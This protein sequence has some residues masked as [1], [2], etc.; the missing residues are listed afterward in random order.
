MIIINWQTIE[1]THCGVMSPANVCEH[2]LKWWIH[3]CMNCVTR[4]EGKHTFNVIHCTNSQNTSSIS[5]MSYIYKQ[6][7]NDDWMNELKQCQFEKSY[8]RKELFPICL[9]SR[10]KDVNKTDEEWG[11]TH[12][13][14]MTMFTWKSGGSFGCGWKPSFVHL[15]T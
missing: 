13:T 7:G 10:N 4:L 1:A 9:I 12:K 11:C 14:T 3:L 5:Y 15:E 2:S 8:K 6:F